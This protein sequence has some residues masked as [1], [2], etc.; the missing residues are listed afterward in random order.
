MTQVSK[1]RGETKVVGVTPREHSFWVLEHYSYYDL[2][3]CRSFVTQAQLDSLHEHF[4]ILKAISMRALRRNVLPQEAHEDL[5]E[6]LFSLIA[7]ECRVRLP[8]ALYVRQ[9]L[10]ELSLHLLQVSPSL[11][12]NMIAL[13]IMWHNVHGQDPTSK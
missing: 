11:W 10:S 12:E 6:I 8:L 2:D 4:H 9:L 1:V 7:L 13:Y 5:N 3:Y